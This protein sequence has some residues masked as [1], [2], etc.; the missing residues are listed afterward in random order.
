M[1]TVGLH[2]GETAAQHLVKK[3][4]TAG[5]ED[6]AG[7][8]V[9]RLPG[10]AYDAVDAV[11]V[12]DEQRRLR[13]LIRLPNLL[14]ASPNQLVSELM[15]TQPPAVH[16]GEDQER[17][18]LLAITHGVAAVPVIDEAGHLLGV[19]PAQALI[20][21]LRRE[22]IEDLHRLT[23]IAPENA[24]VRASL[25]AP[26]LRRLRDRLPWLLVG[27]LGSAA[28]T[29][30]M[31]RFERA[32][33]ARVAVAFFIPALVY[34][35]D[36]I[37]TQTE[38]ITVRFLSTQHAPL[39]RLLVGELRTGVLIGLALGA[40]VFPAVLLAFGDVNLAL[41]VTVALVA[42]GGIAAT[43]GLLLPWLLSWAGRDP[44]LG[45]GPVAT[46]IQDVLSL[47]IYLA[48]VTLLIA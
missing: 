4:P 28:A 13:G 42:A 5:V 48:C 3:V 17:I 47:L 24:Q 43:V 44:A 45:S 27:L 37:G 36:A 25:E 31:A 11:Y 16:P 34:L 19:V 30:V 41:A 38:A 2:A 10:H 15:L 18:A 9:A 46:I 32:L 40:F 1:E 6:T 12:V 8:V 20:E 29:F 23:G 14:A 21:I 26:P 22:H 33:E 7:S 35:A 39:G